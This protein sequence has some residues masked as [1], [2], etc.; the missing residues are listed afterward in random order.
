MQKVSYKNN[1]RFAVFLSL[2]VLGAGC[3]ETVE[4]PASST[5]L[6]LPKASVNIS[7]G[8]TRV[9]SNTAEREERPEREVVID[10]F[11]ID[12]TEVTNAQFRDF[13]SQTGYVSDAEKPQPGFG[14]AGAAVFTM[15]SA[16]SPNWWRFVEGANWQNPEGPDSS[17]EGRESDPVVQVSYADA[18]A[19]ATWAGRRLP[20]EFEWEHAAKGG[21]DTR[22][23]W[24]EE[25]NP[26][27]QQMA[28]IWQG[29]FPVKNTNEDGYPLRAPVGCF[30]PNTYGLY[31]MI[32]NV[33]E[34]TD[35]Q[36]RDTDGEPT[37]VIKGGSFLCADNYCR[38]YRA[39]ARQPQEAG[40]S[41]NHIGFRTVE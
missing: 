36:Y 30:P 7:G 8:A 3:S 2:A 41:T 5:C 21:S 17:I 25:K 11:N 37:Y 32:G 20:T 34:W 10:T 24:G 31:D 33:W 14:V 22:Y 39:S 40:F 38:R 15:P 9:G 28:N 4:T 27:G 18:K 29:A 19:Y 1:I 6:S 35:T 23:V 16:T 12:A 13:V 26:N